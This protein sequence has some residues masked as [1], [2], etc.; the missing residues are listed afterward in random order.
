MF[1]L[2]S[3]VQSA[4]GGARDD[5][6]MLVQHD[7]AER[8]A[9]TARQSDERAFERSMEF[10]SAQAVAQR[11]FVEKM[12]STSFQR[13]MADMAAAGLNPMLAAKVGGADSPSGASASISGTKASPAQV[14]ASHAS[15][16]GMQMSQI[17]LNSASTERTRAETEVAHATAE[18]IRRRTPVHAASID[19][20][21]QDVQES[22]Q[23]VDK[24]IVDMSATRQ[25]EA[26]S[27]SQASHL[28]QQVRNLREVI[29][30]IRATVENL[31]AHSKLLGSEDKAVQQ[32]V[33]A[34]LPELERVLKDLERSI[35]EMSLPGHR[36]DE[37]AADSMLGQLKSYLRGLIPLQ[38]IF[39]SVP[40]GRGVPKAPKYTPN[41]ANRNPPGR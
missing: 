18:E 15:N 25:F 14:P 30:Q 13:G 26:T 37:A 35:T 11:E 12:S 22:I 29:P 19:K 32:K 6:N 5:L 34:N 1:G 24:M 31:R 8:A 40:L 27:A 7:W 28:E 16:V 41:P 4:F 33:A 3:L 21:K 10:N 2:G 17:E 38:G 20:L 39:G 9:A 36:N 23:R